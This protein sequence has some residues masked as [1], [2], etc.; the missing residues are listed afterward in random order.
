M[1]GLSKMS[2]WN[3]GGVGTGVA[4]SGPPSLVHPA[5]RRAH[6]RIA[7]E[8]KGTDT[9]FLSQLL[10]FFIVSSPQTEDP[11]TCVVSIR[12]ST[13]HCAEIETNCSSG[14]HLYHLKVVRGSYQDP[15]KILVQSSLMGRVSTLKSSVPLPK[16]NSVDTRGDPRGERRE[17]P[18]TGPAGAFSAHSAL[19]LPSRRRIAFE[20]D[21][22]QGI[23]STVISGHLECFFEKRR[24]RSGV[25][26][27]N[28][29]S[30]NVQVDDCGCRRRPLQRCGGS[31][32]RFTKR[33]GE[34]PA[35]PEA[36]GAHTTYIRKCASPLFKGHLEES[37]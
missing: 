7:R 11:P 12:P 9:T 23:S 35:C 25:C 28:S 29:S 33:P 30:Q 2:G 10:S 18:C 31:P 27:I 34:R 26:P 17:R 15:S 13:V 6:P 19:L 20:T 24:V 8:S 22:P 37:I 1:I 14:V 36:K 3:V 32:S 4:L 21:Q 16:Y 5:I